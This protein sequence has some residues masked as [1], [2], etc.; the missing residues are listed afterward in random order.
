MTEILLQMF[1]SFMGTLMFSTLFNVE[2]KYFAGCGLV[3]MCGW[4]GYYFA[5][6]H[7][8]AATC[9]FIGTVI[10]VIA[11][12]ILAIQMKCPM[13]VFLVAGIFPLVPGAGVYHT[14]YYLVTGDMPKAAAYGLGALQN[15]F[16]IVLG[17]VF[18]LAV[19]RKYYHTSYW[20][21][22]GKEQG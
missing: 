19:P 11:S 15:A 17:I 16:G 22:R 1:C 20:K 12:N 6:E 14:A 21:H 4:M 3:G 13:T 10:I 9:C 2:K 18:V 5:Q 7:L 8:S